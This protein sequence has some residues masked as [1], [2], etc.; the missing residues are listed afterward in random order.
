[1]RDVAK[2][3]GS[4]SPSSCVPRRD[5]D[6]GF[7]FPRA[8]RLLHTAEYDAVYESGQRR[9]GKHFVVFYRRR[10]VPDAESRFG[11]S[12]KRSQ[13]GAVARNRIK[14]RVREILRL[15]RQEIATGW[16]IVIHPRTS[17]LMAPFGALEAEL[18]ELLKSAVGSGA[19]PP[20]QDASTTRST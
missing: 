16:D 19:V 14:R 12:V 5:G 10:D 11:I 7:D 3:A 17:V 8:C 20:P 1:L 9:A 13:G 2:P 18:V 6:E 15:H 4:A